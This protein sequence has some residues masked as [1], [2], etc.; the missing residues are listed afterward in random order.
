MIKQLV[1]V[2]CVLASVAHADPKPKTAT[3]RVIDYQTQGDA[4]IVTVHVGSN[5]GVA[6]TWRAKFR[7]GTTTKQLVGGEATVI[8][9]D[10]RSTVLKTNLTPEQI[11]ANRSVQF[12]R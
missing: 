8:R 6:R 7:E 4:R 5:Q 9:I 1:V 2:M 11:R 12:D 10:K 3:G